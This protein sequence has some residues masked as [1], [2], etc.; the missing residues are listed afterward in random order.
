MSTA[1]A[2]RKF[3]VVVD[4]KHESAVALRFATRRAQHTGGRITLAVMDDPLYRAVRDLE[5]R[6]GIR[7]GT[8]PAAVQ[9]SVRL[10][11]DLRVAQR[12]IR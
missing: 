9:R 10:R 8:R 3:L 11:S 7:D 1:R 2:P 12:H 5:D 4:K 6:I